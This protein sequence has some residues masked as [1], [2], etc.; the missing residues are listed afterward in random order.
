MN[1]IP[2]ESISLKTKTSIKLSLNYIYEK[3]NLCNLDVMIPFQK[4]I[5]NNSNEEVLEIL[6]KRMT[7]SQIPQKYFELKKKYSTRI[8]HPIINLFDCINEIAY[9]KYIFDFPKNGNF[10][11]F[12]ESFLSSIKFNIYLLGS[13]HMV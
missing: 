6:Y 4:N 5:E 11:G 1:L 8:G 12:Q 2:K 10:W 7:Y 13:T 3:L 9:T